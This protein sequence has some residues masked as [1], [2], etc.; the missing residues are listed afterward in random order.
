VPFGV[1]ALFALMAHGDYDPA[2]VLAIVDHQDA[3]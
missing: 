1:E 2:A 3:A